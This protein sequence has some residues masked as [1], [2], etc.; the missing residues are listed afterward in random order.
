MS[1]SKTFQCPA[2]PK[3]KPKRA[4]IR[5]LLAPQAGIAESILRC[6]ISLLFGPCLVRCWR[7][8]L[9]LR[10]ARFIR[11]KAQKVRLSKRNYNKLRTSIACQLLAVDCCSKNIASRT[12]KQ[13]KKEASFC[14]CGAKTQ[15]A[16]QEEY[17]T[18]FVFEMKLECK[19]SQRQTDSENKSRNKYTFRV[20]KSTHNEIESKR[21]QAKLSRKL[22]H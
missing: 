4:Q 10:F 1:G 2:K 21:N 6:A 17:L 12:S 18:R 15:T 14:V 8:K 5:A 9:G 19:C 22:L 7:A 16:R 20:N 13:R 3:T 11:F